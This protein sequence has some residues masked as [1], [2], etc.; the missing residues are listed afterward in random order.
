MSE[1]PAQEVP[2][3]GPWKRL[4]SRMIGA[5]LIRMML[6]IG[7][8]AFGWAFLGQ[9]DRSV[10]GTLIVLTVMAVL[11]PAYY[12]LQFF[13]FRY[14]L[15]ATELQISSGLV[16]RRTHRVPLHR[17]RTVDIIAPPVLRLLSLAIVTIGTGEQVT[18]RNTA[19][20]LDAVSTTVAADLRDELLAAAGMRASAS[21]LAG[22]GESTSPVPEILRLRWVWMVYAVVS[23]WSLVAPAAMFGFAYQGL[24]FLGRDPDTIVGWYFSD[25]LEEVSLTRWLVTTVGVFVLVAAAGAAAVFAEAWWNYVLV[26]EQHGR[27]EQHGRFVATRGFLTTRSFTVD[28]SRLRGVTVAE[29]LTTRLLG[30]ARLIPIL[31][32]VSADQQNTKSGVLVPAT[33]RD[34][35]IALANALLSEPVLSDERLG[36]GWLHHHPAA[37]QRR[38]VFRYLTPVVLG[39]ALLAAAT[40][41]W[42]WP[43]WLFIIPAAATAILVPSSVGHYR[44]LGHRIEDGYLF[45]RRGFFLRRYDAV[46]LRGISG[47]AVHQT[48]FQR[49]LGLA[50]VIAT[51]ASGDKAYH[52][53]DVDL[54]TATDLAVALGPQEFAPRTCV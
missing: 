33:T 40:V 30:G 52:V 6:L 31:T 49:R 23:V 47:V 17:I 29:A 54:A 2:A 34:V 53:V 48:V 44:G 3:P 39:T 43:L 20:K 8:V 10:S 9:R 28:Q 42:S 12:I 36:P 7:P 46:Q 41:L 51:T 21:S 14:R 16:V 24:Q 25:Y 50:S 18:G 15:T 19:L 26:H 27:R 45:S 13:R 35:P 38:I 11:V 5:A 4:D 22:S 1:A 37:A 32:G